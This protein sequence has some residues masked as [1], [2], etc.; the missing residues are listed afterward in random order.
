M[1]IVKELEKGFQQTEI[2]TIPSEWKIVPLG[3]YAKFING[4]AYALYEW[5][6]HGTP[7]IRLQNLTGSGDNYYYSNLKLP[8]KQYCNFGDLLFMWSATFG[9][10]IWKGERAIYHYHIW[11]VETEQNHLDKWFLFHVLE[12]LTARVKRDSTNGGTMLHVTKKNMQETLIPFPPIKAEQ[13][14][15][16]TVLNDAD[17][18]ITELEKLIAKKRNIKQGAMQELL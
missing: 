1:A 16:A 3:Q 7:V 14:A 4:R 12:D 17:K 15:I 10:V 9:P 6:A 2:G 5:E 13:T 11:K 8:E 18:L